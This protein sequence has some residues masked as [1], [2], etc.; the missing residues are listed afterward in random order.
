MSTSDTTE[1]PPDDLEAQFLSRMAKLTIKEPEVN[2]MDDELCKTPTRPENQI[3]VLN[4]PPAPRKKRPAPSSTS[5]R[6]YTVQ[7]VIVLQETIDAFFRASGESSRVVK[8]RR[9]N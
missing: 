3:R 4:C 8:R 5:K 7:Y 2:D 1:Q 9:I 6:L